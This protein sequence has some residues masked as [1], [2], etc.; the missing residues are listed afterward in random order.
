MQLTV[1]STLCSLYSHTHTHTLLYLLYSFYSHTHTLLYST[2]LATLATLVTPLSAPLATPSLQH[3]LHH[4]QSLSQLVTRLGR[5]ARS[6]PCCRL[7][8]C[9]GFRHFCGVSCV[10]HVV[11]GG[12]IPV[13]ELCVELAS[14]CWHGVD[15][16]DS[17]LQRELSRSGLPTWHR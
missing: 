8:H 14:I 1:P 17:H 5:Y 16:R 3:N 9:T 13:C 12:A 2:S 11:W 6:F 10:P 7:F 15:Y 4:H